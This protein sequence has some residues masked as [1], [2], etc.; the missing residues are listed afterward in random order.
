MIR[1]CSWCDKYMGQKE[2]LDDL[3]VTLSVCPEC[4]ED[5][6]PK[7]NTIRGLLVALPLSLVLWGVI[8]TCT[9]RPLVAVALGVA[10]AAVCGWIAGKSR[11]SPKGKTC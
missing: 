2:P 1:I 9:T 3:S 7:N 11:R 6:E 8:F 10:F 4:L 5:L